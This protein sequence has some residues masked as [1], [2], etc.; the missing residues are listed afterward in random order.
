LVTIICWIISALAL[1]GLATWFILGSTFN[2]TVG[3]GIVSLS[4]PFEER[5]SYNLSTAGTDSMYID[6]V[7]G[8]I[9]I[10]P[11][12][13]SEIQ[14]TEF[15]QRELRSGEEFVVSTQGSTLRIEF[16]GNRRLQNLPPKNLE[17]LV[18][19]TLMGAFREVTVNTVS[20][21]VDIRDLSATTLTI[22]TVSGAV[23]LFNT[24]APSLRVGT[25]SGRVELSATTADTMRLRTV[26]GRIELTDARAESLDV[27][28]TS[29]TQTL[30]G[31][32]GTI[33]TGSV[34]GRIEITS[35]ILP[36]SLTAGTVSGAIAIT[37]PDEGP[38]SVEHSSVSGRFESELPVLMHGA[39]VQFRLSTTSGRVNIYALG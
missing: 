15:S 24:T 10:L 18:P 26:S 39:E 5:G 2:F 23:E 13:G 27:S 34:S 32:F 19:H 25:T 11:H 9:T 30:S 35:T 14:V 31:A 12:D 22:D 4:G 1:V 7:A 8:S 36:S 37:V 17:V 38:I 20:G 29:G 6:W 28:T 21:P 3:G 33:D 16:S